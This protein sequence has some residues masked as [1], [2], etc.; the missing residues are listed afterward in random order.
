MAES[1]NR[2]KYND[3]YTTFLFQCLKTPNIVLIISCWQVSSLVNLSLHK[4]GESL[5]SAECLCPNSISAWVSFN[6]CWRSPLTFAFWNLIS[7]PATPVPYCFQVRLK[8]H[9]TY[10]PGLTTNNNSALSAFSALT[11]LVGRQE[12]HPACKK[13]GVMRCC[14][15]YLSGSRC[16]WFAYGS[17]DATAT[18]SSLASAKSRMVYPSGTAYPGCPG[19]KSR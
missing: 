9:S 15:G 16:K 19:K 1:E 8:H 7:S 14:R 3:K 18:P 6:L 5:P 17:A 12:G 4:L 2:Y 10:L 11:L 13:Y